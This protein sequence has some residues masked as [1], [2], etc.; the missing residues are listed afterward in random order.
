MDTKTA[1]RLLKDLVMAINNNDISEE[2]FTVI[3]KNY[4]EVK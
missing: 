4:I 2:S 3:L 1:K